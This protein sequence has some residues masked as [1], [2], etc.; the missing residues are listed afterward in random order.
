[1][2]APFL[3]VVVPSYN[4]LHSLADT[5]DG[6]RAQSLDATLF[7]VIVI[8]NGSVDGTYEAVARRAQEEPFSLRV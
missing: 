4:R 6:L 1:M 7:E 5:L 2:A 3:S 8:D